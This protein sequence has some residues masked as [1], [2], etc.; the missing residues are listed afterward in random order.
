M[1]IQTEIKLLKQ[2][3]IGQQFAFTLRLNGNP[4]VTVSKVFGTVAGINTI[5]IGATLPDTLN[6][7]AAN[8]TTYNPFLGM[9]YV[10]LG[11]SVMAAYQL[12]AAFAENDLFVTDI[13]DVLDFIR[14]Y[15]QDGIPVTPFTVNN[16][17]IEIIDTYDNNR[18]LFIE[19]AQAD[20]LKLTWDGGEG[21]Y[22]PMMTSRLSFSITRPSHADGQYLHL[23]T[24]DERRY[25]VRLKNVDVND[26][27]ILLWQGYILPDT[28]SEPYKNGV[29]FVSFTAT[30]M[31]A[32]LKGKEFKPWFYAG[33]FN[34]PELFGYILAETGLQQEMYVTPA[35]VNVGY[36]DWQWRNTNLSLESFADGKKYTDLYTILETVLTAQGLQITSYR[37]K[38][39]LQGLTRR[40]AF[41]GPAEVY[42]PDGVFKETLNYVNEVVAAKYS[43]GAP[44]I[45]GLTP[46]KTVALTFG[47]NSKENAFSENVVAGDYYG[48]GYDYETDMFTDIVLYP[49][50]P[51]GVFP[52]LNFINRSWVKIGAPQ[53]YIAPNQPFTE[54]IIDIVGGV[55]NMPEASALINHIRCVETPGIVAGRRY[56]LEITVEAQLSFNDLYNRDWIEAR[57]KDGHFNRLVAFQ[58]LLDGQEYLSNRPGFSSG[59][60]LLFTQTL[61]LASAVTVIE[62]ALEYEF[63][64]PVS[65][66]VTFNFI[67]PLDNILDYDVSSFVLYPRVLKLTTISDIE[68]L[69]SVTATRDINYT[70]AEA[71]S[72]NFTCTSDA[73]VSNSFGYGARVG[74]RYAVIPTPVVTLFNECQ[75]YTIN[76]NVNF[77]ALYMAKWA[78]DEAIQSIVFSANQRKALFLTQADGTEILYPSLY[79]KKIDGVYYMAAYHHYSSDN[80]AKPKLPDDYYGLP[81][82][83]PGDV[84]RLMF[85]L[86]MPEDKTKRAL[87]KI[88][89]FDD[90]GAATYMQTLAYA[91]HA[92][93]PRGVFDIDATA[94]K[95][96][97][98]TQ[99]L[100]FRYLDANRY[101]I[102]TYIEADLFRG[103][104]QVRLKEA[105]L[106]QLTDITY[107]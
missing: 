91:Y 4:V 57:I 41:S 28:Y 70:D 7:I 52:Y 74:N 47:G 12:T 48:T 29:V 82:I 89:G 93:R 55:Y 98:P 27:A 44:N 10:V 100:V 62:F 105:V 103:K 75:Q 53:I 14:V 54:F 1:Y 86:F 19:F 46:L 5:V 73:A 58:I 56:L 3:V 60:A 83:E 96:I 25:L 36:P 76:G 102:P 69:E 26:N 59:S 68:D 64:V 90:A 37:G 16:F 61:K 65:G 101:F 80:N 72:V 77:I 17:A 87:W 45:D 84:L 33:V 2:P 49:A 6:N 40:Q 106:N 30:D 32:L 107:E 50:V 63:V 67:G 94:L 8:L 79:T 38:W 21:L 78:I 34:L 51:T 15:V 22:Q 18:D 9:Q 95:L 20:S 99:L 11:G 24:G 85:N 13:I 66:V 35:L 88:Y 31:L 23:L 39:F 42:H 71:A 81:Y 97:F 92:V 43:A 104:T